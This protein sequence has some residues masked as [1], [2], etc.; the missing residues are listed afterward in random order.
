MRRILANILLVGVTPLTLSGCFVELLGATAITG[1][2]QAEQA[3]NVKPVLDNANNTAAR[4]SLQSSVDAFY[5]DRGYRP[6]RLDRL[7]PGYVPTLPRQADGAPF[8]YDPVTGKVLD[9]PGALSPKPADEGVMQ[10]VRLAIDSYAR[11]TGYYPS[12]LDQLAPNY[13]PEI[14]KTTAGERFLY[15][16]QTGAVSHP[17]PGG[18]PVPIAQPQR[19][20]TSQLEHI[21]HDYGRQQNEVMDRLGL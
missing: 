10:D 17:R 13:Y 15:D 12:T 9:G 14:P 16:N 4:T 3:K 20:D 18:A 7:V 21:Q 2:L 5:A 1:T 8:G 11:D 6:D 19:R